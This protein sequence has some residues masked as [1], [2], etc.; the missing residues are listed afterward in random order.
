MRIFHVRSL[1]FISILLLLPG[2]C[3][4]FFFDPYLQYGYDDAGWDATS[5]W[6][7]D[8]STYGLF[9][10]TIDMRK[11]HYTGLMVINPLPDKGHRVVFMTE[12]G[13][14]IFDM[15]FTG[16]DVFKLHYFMDVLNR[17]TVVRTLRNDIG[18]IVRNE[19]GDHF[20]SVLYDRQTG[21][22][23]IRV[24][25]ERKRYYYAVD[26]ETNKI[27]S[28]IHT[29]PLFRKVKA[30]FYSAGGE[31]LDSVILDHYNMKLNIK[32]TQIDAI[33]PTVYE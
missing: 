3:A 33:T 6:F 30:D 29:S 7:Q 8:D 2:G 22:K 11:N 26:D 5:L 23:V 31:R 9:N 21:N 17:K 24:R 10:T 18:L 1:V 25:K 13:M 28:V 15:E 20:Y 19:I 16:G 4:V 27:T 14:K 32:L 12:F